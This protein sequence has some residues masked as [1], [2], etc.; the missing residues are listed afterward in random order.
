MQSNFLKY[1]FRKLF[2]LLGSFFLII[3]LTF[4]LMK[5]L[6]GDP[7]D[8]EQQ[9]P[10]E[11]QTALRNHYGLDKPLYVQYANYLQSILKW[12]FGPSFKYKDRS[13]NEIINEGFS[14]SAL[15]GLE[16]I[17][18]A[19][20]AGVLLGMFAALKENQWQDDIAMILATL[21]VSVPSFILATL[22]QYVIAIKWGLLPLAR[23][24][25]FSHTVL[26]A[27]ALAALPMAFIAR[28]IRANLIEILQCDYI[29]MAKAKGLSNKT[30][31]LKHALR[32][33]FLPV[34]TYLGQLVANVLVGSFVIEKIFSIP[35][36]GQWFVNSVSNRDYTVIMGLT[37]FY[38]ALLLSTTFLVDLAYGYLDPRIQIQ[39]E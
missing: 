12:D 17:C 31:L 5:I 7:F 29:K 20:C 24:G 38:S 32:N 13:V 18:L 8:D 14:V 19:I 39:K 34:L 15:L 26:P 9:L 10:V 6:P 27:I 16:A 21:C 22:L 1:L 37:I 28:L 11:I 36:L 30:I 23:W 4:F 25:T 35:G 2:F 33:A 3:T